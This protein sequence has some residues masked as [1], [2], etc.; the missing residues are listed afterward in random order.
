M[1]AEICVIMI[2]ITRV[3]HFKT[4]DFDI[5]AHNHTFG[6]AMYTAQRTHSMLSSAPV[7]VGDI[8]HGHM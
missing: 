2:R 3:T 1:A 6:H 5:L 7:V 8:V 4:P